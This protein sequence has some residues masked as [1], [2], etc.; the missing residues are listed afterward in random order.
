M[1]KG[2]VATLCAGRVNASSDK[3]VHLPTSCIVLFSVSRSK[4]PP[5][6]LMA[7][8]GYRVKGMADAVWL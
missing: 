1:W 7:S 6:A 2:T 4:P 8:A 3:E 5:C